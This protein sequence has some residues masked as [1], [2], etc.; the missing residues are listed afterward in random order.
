MT[1]SQEF[2]E[3]LGSRNLLT[4]QEL[5]LSGNKHISYSHHAVGE[6]NLSYLPPGVTRNKTILTMLMVVDK[7]EIDISL[8]TLSY[9]FID[10]NICMTSHNLIE[11]VAERKWSNLEF[12]TEVINVRSPKD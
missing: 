1:S 4:K 11:S 12:D 6:N 3:T 8:C 9:I 5:Q 7:I 2:W 10:Q